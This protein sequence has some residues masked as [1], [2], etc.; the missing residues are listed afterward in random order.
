MQET[1]AP[2][3]PEEWGGSI[4]HIPARSVL[5]PNIREM[6]HKKI[7]VPNY[8]QNTRNYHTLKFKWPYNMNLKEAWRSWQPWEFSFPFY[9]QQLRLEFNLQKCYVCSTLLCSFSFSLSVHL[10]SFSTLSFICTSSHMIYRH[11]F[12]LC[13]SHLALMHTRLMQI[14]KNARKRSRERLNYG[15]LAESSSKALQPWSMQTWSS[16]GV[17]II[18]TRLPAANVLLI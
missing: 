11:I 5:V 17:N 6:T 18:L 10:S 13:R 2:R 15:G 1:V 8:F 3:P 12:I 14:L 4:D 9:V 16:E 7:K